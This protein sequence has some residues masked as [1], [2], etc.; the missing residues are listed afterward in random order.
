LLYSGTPADITSAYD[1]LAAEVS[2]CLN[3]PDRWNDGDDVTYIVED[4]TLPTLGQAATGWR[5]AFADT[6]TR[7]DHRMA[8]VRTGTRLLVV[9][10]YDW[11]GTDDSPP[12]SETDFVTL[13]EDAAARITG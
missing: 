1:A 3:G 8:I 11:V 9:E 10:E 2:T 13:V 6:A 5:Y 4:L 7:V 12:I